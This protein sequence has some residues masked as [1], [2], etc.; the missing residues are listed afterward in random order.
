MVN[1]L[2]RWVPLTGVVYVGLMVAILIG[3]SSPDTKDT[4]AK[5]IAFYQ[6]HHTAAGVQV[7]LLAYAALFVVMF[8]A[9]VSSYLRRRGADQLATVVFGGALLQGAGLTL[10]GGL[11]LALNDHPARLS[12]NAAQ[13]LNLIASDT[14][15]ITLFV[16][17]S[18]SMVAA[19]I[20]ILRTRA[21]PTWLGWVTVVIAIGAL[22]AVGA[23]FAFLATGLWILVVAG[24]LIAR[25]DAGEPS[26][27]GE[28]TVLDV[29][30][31][32]TSADAA[33]SKAPTAG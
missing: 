14:F 30:A 31:A 15:A 2:S 29:P 20:A 24:L 22:T 12:Q 26:V 5:T 7:F 1:R 4:G 10:A 28:P 8:F 9:S 19:G 13:A 6:A 21:F 17:L 25:D 16:G 33:T 23:W 32:R 27:T 11:T 3:P 18:I